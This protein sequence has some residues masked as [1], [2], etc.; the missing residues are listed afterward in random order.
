MQIVKKAAAKSIS[1][2]VP[3]DDLFIN[4]GS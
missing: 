4:G 2:T 3:G 1:T